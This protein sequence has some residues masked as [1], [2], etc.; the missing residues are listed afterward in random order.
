ML[1]QKGDQDIVS[2]AFQQ[3]CDRPDR[4]EKGPVRDMGLLV[5]KNMSSFVSHR[6]ERV[7]GGT[8]T[9][10]SFIKDTLIFVPP[11]KKVVTDIHGFIPTKETFRISSA[12]KGVEGTDHGSSQLRNTQQNAPSSKNSTH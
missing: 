9:H 3:A 12:T 2:L 1:K 10:S 6:L 5:P 11:A 7:V 4:L 8:E